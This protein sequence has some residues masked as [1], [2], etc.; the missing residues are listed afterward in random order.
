MVLSG[1]TKEDFG[2]GKDTFNTNKFLILFKIGNLKTVDMSDSEKSEWCE[3]GDYVFEHLQ[4]HAV[5]A[6]IEFGLLRWQYWT[7][8]AWWQGV[9]PD[10]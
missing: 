7:V 8:W 10:R 9:P 5:G 3:A 4:R 6:G 2:N 1:K